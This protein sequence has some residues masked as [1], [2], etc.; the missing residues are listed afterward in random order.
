MAHKLLIG[1]VFLTILLPRVTASACQ[2]NV[3]GRHVRFLWDGSGRTMKKGALEVSF[4]RY[5]TEAGTL[6]ER[7]VE[8]YKTHEQASLALQNL[9]MTASKRLEDGF[10]QDHQGSKIGRRI[11]CVHSDSRRNQPNVTVAWVDGSRLFRLRSES[12]SVLLSFESQDYPAGG[13]DREKA[14]DK[15]HR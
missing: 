12:Q 7:F 11:V 6:V 2:D 13:N 10:K 9:Y 4:S 3:G 8:S 15:E 14:G 1:F 5:K